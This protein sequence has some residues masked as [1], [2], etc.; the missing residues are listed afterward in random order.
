MEP[1]SLIP[2]ILGFALPHQTPF[3]FVAGSK[4]RAIL[5]DPALTLASLVRLSLVCEPN[6][7]SAYVTASLLSDIHRT[8]RAALQNA[9]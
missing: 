3:S 2:Q 8:L 5:V 7:S 1:S 6:A 9:F 4:W